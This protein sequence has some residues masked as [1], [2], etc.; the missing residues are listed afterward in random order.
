VVPT[1][2]FCMQYFAIESAHLMHLVIGTAL[3]SMIFSTFA[4]TW[5]HQKNHSLDKSLIAYMLPGLLAGAFLGAYF[6]KHL[7]SRVLEILFGIFG[8]FIGLRFILQKKV[9]SSTQ[10]PSCSLKWSYS[11]I[12]VGI[13]FLS[14]LLG[15]GGGIFSVP[16][17]QSLKFPIKKAIATSSAITFFATLFAS[18]CYFLLGLHQIHAAKLEHT[19]LGFIY[20]PAFFLI[21]PPSVAL[22]FLGAKIAH[23]SSTTLLKRAF[24]II[25]LFVGIYMLWG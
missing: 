4:S 21:T 24:G 1:L 10:A 19:S 22:A 7:S 14:A 3:S 23:R 6:A 11:F 20:L 25:L 5:S 2:F 17:L 8:C 9:I 18:L 12:G 15:V 13:S 16:L